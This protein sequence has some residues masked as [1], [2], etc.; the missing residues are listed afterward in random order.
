ME[1]TLPALPYAKDALAPHISAETLEFHHGKHHQAYVT[2]LNNL[3]KGTEFENLDLEAIV[4]KA[5]AGGVYNNSA[6]VWFHTCAELL[7]TP[8]AG[9]SPAARWPTRSRPSGAPSTTSRRPS[10]DRKSVV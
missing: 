10:R 3:I 5:P 1:H 8:P 7:Y 4:K 9:A 2:N 6:K